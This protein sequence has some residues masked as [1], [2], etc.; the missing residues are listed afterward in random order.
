M[1][2]SRNIFVIVLCILY[3]LPS[4]SKFFI[5]KPNKVVH[6]I[7]DSISII[8]TINAFKKSEKKDSSVKF[9]LIYFLRKGYCHKCIRVELDRGWLT[10]PRQ[11]GRIITPSYLFYDSTGKSLGKNNL[12][13]DGYKHI[14]SNKKLITGRSIESLNECAA[15]IDS[16][17]KIVSIYNIA[18]LEDFNRIFRM[19]DSV[20]FWN[21]AL[22]LN[23]LPLLAENII[24]NSNGQ[25]IP[26]DNFS[27]PSIIRFSSLASRFLQI[28][29][30]MKYRTWLLDT[31]G[32]IVKTFRFVIYDTTRKS[33][34]QPDDYFFYDSS[35]IRYSYTIHSKPEKKVIQGEEATLFTKTDY[36]V[37]NR[38]YKV[39]SLKYIENKYA[40]SYVS[41]H[42]CLST[43]SDH[44]WQP[45]LLFVDTIPAK[46][47][48]LRI[49]DHNGEVKY[50]MKF[51][52]TLLIL[53]DKETAADS[54]NLYKINSLGNY[55]RYNINNDVLKSNVSYIPNNYDRISTQLSDSLITITASNDSKR[56]TYCYSTLGIRYTSC[57]FIPKESFAYLD[58]KH[59]VLY[60]LS[61][62]KN[63]NQTKEYWVLRKYNA[64]QLF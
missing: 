45:E 5:Y 1:I 54:I 50:N 3:T 12:L 56:I 38:Q 64:S 53:E 47:F 10:I 55:F 34:F 49:L 30:P 32:S 43:N 9:N 40:E 51:D 21:N 58:A 29:N 62:E 20:A 6:Q 4:F 63:S 59:K 14:N 11:I 28:Y 39:D 36:F 41:S 13:S 42:N 48:N 46:Y 37:T 8:N 35:S 33:L 44:V 25:D 16:K 52:T 2:V 57:V 15:L 26:K 22:E 61:P 17:N 31:N 18:D 27:S 60:I 7:Q 24:K 19:V 23:Q